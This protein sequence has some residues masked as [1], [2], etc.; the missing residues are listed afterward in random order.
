MTT[1]AYDGKCLAADSLVTEG[2]M[3]VGRTTK[4]GKVGRV[5]FGVS[6]NLGQ[7]IQF[8]DW[9]RGGMRGD[10]PSFLGVDGDGGSTAI[11][12]ANGRILTWDRDRWDVLEAP[13]Y[14]I[15]SGSKIAMGAMHVGATA[16]QAV[17][18][19]IDL[20][21]SSGGKIVVLH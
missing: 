3:R 19:G 4:I 1:I 2:G 12:I 15:G 9:M 20:D 11:V 10:P 18:A 7:Q 17:R 14:A 8:Q 6:G 13:Y 5:L 21:T 16:V